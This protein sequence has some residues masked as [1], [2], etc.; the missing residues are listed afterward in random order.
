MKKRNTS[1]IRRS[2]VIIHNIGTPQVPTK[3]KIDPQVCF[4]LN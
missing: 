1:V 3:N 2:D 4:E